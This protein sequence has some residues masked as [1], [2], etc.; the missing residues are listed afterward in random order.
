MS[1]FQQ[2]PAA[3]MTCYQVNRVY[4]DNNRLRVDQARVTGLSRCAQWTDG[5][6]WPTSRGV[7]GSLAAG[8]SDD[9]ASCGV[10]GVEL[11]DDGGVRSGVKYIGV[12]KDSTGTAL[13]GATVSAYLTVPADMRTPAA[14]VA[15]SVVSDAGGYFEAVS[16]F[17]STDHYIVAYKPGS[18][19]VAGTSKNNLRFT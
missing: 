3:T 1:R 12:T 6:L 13:A 14:P 15:A 7:G 9:A 17:P 16:P 4:G 5:L 10:W 8:I 11:A 18:P 2:S 19:D